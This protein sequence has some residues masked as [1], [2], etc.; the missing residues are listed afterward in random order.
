MFEGAV[1][2]QTRRLWLEGLTMYIRV[3][4]DLDTCTEHAK[5]DA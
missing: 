5:C 4:Y 2:N 3:F 1:E